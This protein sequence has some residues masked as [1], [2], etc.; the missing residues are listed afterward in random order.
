MPVRDPAW[1]GV[2]L[3]VSVQEAPAAILVPQVVEVIANSE[4]LLELAVPRAAAAVPELFSVIVV[5]LLAP[6][7]VS[8]NA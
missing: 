8:G 3:T 7:L 2:N 1:L 6:K 4:A 5:V